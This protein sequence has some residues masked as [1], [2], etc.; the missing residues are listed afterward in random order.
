MNNYKHLKPEQ[1]YI[2]LHD[3]ITVDRLRIS[4]SLSPKIPKE[5]INKGMEAE[6]ERTEKAVTHMMLYFEKGDR[7]LK[8][9]EDIARWIEDDKKKDLRI[10]SSKP[11]TGISCLLCKGEMEC[12]SI[13]LHESST[14]DTV[15]FMYECKGCNTRRAFY[16]NGEE[17]KPKADICPKC[18]IEMAK[19]HEKTK[20]SITTI[21]VCPRCQYK[22]EYVLNLNEEKAVDPNF[23]ADRKRFCLSE[24]EGQEYIKALENIKD[25]KRVMDD[26]EERKKNKDVYD[27]VASLKKLPIGEIKRIMAEALEKDSYG[28]LQFD[29]PELGRYVAVSFTAQ[30]NKID[31]QEY[32][33]K[34][35]LKKLIDN[36]LADTNWRLMS[37]GISYR[38]G[39]V[40]GRIR[41]YEGEEELLKIV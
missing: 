30:D 28:D 12:I 9:K 7:Y 14:M 21:S 16:E 20:N 41:G 32:D 31:R 24:D 40:S 23:E 1:Y 33:S 6:A 26:I 34:H 18:N 13:D 38:M 36:I 27:K 5:K 22:D 2:D 17:Y 19:S 29:K 8:K 39:Y 11:F 10:E 15:L 4:E 25:F 35:K 3:K 37:D